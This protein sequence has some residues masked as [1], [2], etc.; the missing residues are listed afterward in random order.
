MEFLLAFV[1]LLLIL[2]GLIGCFVPV[3]P[4]VVLAYAGLFVMSFCDA[5]QITATQLWVYLALSIVVS[6]AD[7]VLPAQ[8]TK[9]AGGSKEGIRG[10]TAGMIAGML[11][12]GIIGII[13]GPFVGAVVGELIRDGRDKGRALRSGMASFAAFLVGTGLKFA[14]TLAMA[15]SIFGEIWLMIKNVIS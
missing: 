13:I 1:A 11:L 14:L 2:L 3:L 4:G 9:I 5:S 8:L 10:A 7:F 12:G 15:W 6:I